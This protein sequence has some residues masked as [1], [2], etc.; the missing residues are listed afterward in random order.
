LGQ[1]RPAGH[2]LA[3]QLRGHRDGGR[4]P[5]TAGV[6]GSASYAEHDSAFPE[7]VSD[8]RASGGATR[9]QP[10][11]RKRVGPC[12]GSRDCALCNVAENRRV[13]ATTRVGENPRLSD[14]QA[15]SVRQSRETREL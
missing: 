6:N 4:L 3:G 13:L 9:I 7:L 15:V 5:G 10:P 11:D 1:I 2:A 12:S 14:L 8:A